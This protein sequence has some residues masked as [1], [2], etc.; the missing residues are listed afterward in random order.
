MEFGPDRWTTV[1]SSVGRPPPKAGDLSQFGK[2]SKAAP[3]VI[4]PSSVFTKKDNKRDSLSRTSS[5]S[6]MFSMFRQNP[7]LAV[8][9]T[10]K[11]SRPLSWKPSVDPG[12]GGA[13][14]PPQRR[15]L[16]LL[17]RL[18]PTSTEETPPPASEG[19]TRPDVR[20]R[21]EEED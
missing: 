18:K 17:P 9:A 10:A 12:Q 13:P 21:C 14:E 2:I 8:D 20:N 6:G 11:S 7:E 4:G 1:S 5:R 16:Q 3:M 15:K 19:G